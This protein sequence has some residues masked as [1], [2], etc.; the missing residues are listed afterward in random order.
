MTQTGSQKLRGV[1]IGAG[2]FALFQHEAWSR[3]PEVE[4]V[5]VCDQVEDK[6]RAMQQQFGIAKSYTRWEE[7]L[8][9]E[10]PDF[11][12][13]IT[14]PVTHE[15]MC[16]FA[17]R[18]GI[19][20]ICQ[21]PLAPTLEE[22]TRIVETARAAGVRFM[23]HENWRWQPWYRKIKEIQSSGTIGEFTHVHVLTRM[24]DGWGERAYL[25]RQPF[26]REYPRL[27]LYETGVHFIDVFRY[28]LGEVTNVCAYLR[29]LNPVIQGEDAAQLFLRF[30]SG[31]TAIW[32]ANRYNESESRNPRYTFGEIRVDGTAGHLTMDSES[33]IRVKRL[34]EPACDVAYAREDRNFTGDS[35]YATEQHFVDCLISG[36]EFESSGAEYLKT[37]KV[38][39]QAYASALPVAVSE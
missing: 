8:E 18:R 11:A 28:L 20:V 21:K 3:I 22:A 19:H 26:F 5:A 2:Y 7:M 30:E 39:F 35:V 15:E 9:Q 14:P 6:A 33:N 29:R 12:D 17:A 31:A 13:I 27:L 25:D 37:L 32:D 23:V 10:K 36:R 38:L 4:I 34:G 1:T 24:G 16:A